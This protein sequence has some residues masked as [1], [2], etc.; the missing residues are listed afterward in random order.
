[1]KA[2]QVIWNNFIMSDIL[3][4]PETFIAGLSFLQS[5]EKTSTVVSPKRLCCKLNYV[6]KEV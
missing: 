2:F 5:L 1:M 3:I 4:H 6:H